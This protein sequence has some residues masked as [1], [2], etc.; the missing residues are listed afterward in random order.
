MLSNGK[1]KSVKHRVLSKLI[2]PRISIASFFSKFYLEETKKF[3]PIKELLSDENPPKYREITMKEWY[4]V[5]NME[6]RVDETL[7]LQYFKI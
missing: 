6:K 1:F 2:G 3:G 4:S 5:Y 7:N